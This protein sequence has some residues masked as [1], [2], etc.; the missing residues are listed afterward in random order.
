MT[1][2]Y[3]TIIQV[4]VLSE[5]PYEYLGL[6]ELQYDITDGGCSGKTTVISSETLTGKQMAR[7]LKE[8]GSDPEFFNL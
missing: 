2:Y 6:K 4:E 1:K 3:K 8:Q 7:A 5:D